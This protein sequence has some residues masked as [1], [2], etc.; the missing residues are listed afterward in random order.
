SGREDTWIAGCVDWLEVVKGGVDPDA[1]AE[2]AAQLLL[3]AH[4]AASSASFRTFHRDVEDTIR[5][6]ET[7]LSMPVLAIGGEGALGQVVLDLAERYANDVKGAVFPC[8]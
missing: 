3:S 7:P 2:Y 6:R 1:I 4:L 5:D 8:G